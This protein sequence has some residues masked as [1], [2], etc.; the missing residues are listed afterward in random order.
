[1]ENQPNFENK[2]PNEIIRK[3]VREKFTSSGQFL[4]AILDYNKDKT[5]GVANDNSLEDLMAKIGSEYRSAIYLTTVHY[6]PE[7]TSE[8]VELNMKNIYSKGLS[9]GAKVSAFYNGEIDLDQLI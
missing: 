7:V 2:N 3:Q 6:H 9:L 5:P 4:Q 1:M 8:D